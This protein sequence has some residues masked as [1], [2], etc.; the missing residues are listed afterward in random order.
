MTERLIGTPPTLRLTLTPNHTLTQ[1]ASVVGRLARLS[2]SAG[3]AG[4]RVRH[5]ER[6]SDL[7]VQ[8]LS[9]RNPLV[10]ELTGSA[11]TLA[12]VYF[13]LRDPRG[14]GRWVWDVATGF[15]EGHE[16]FRR[17]R[18]KATRPAAD[19]LELAAETALEVEQAAQELQPYLGSAGL[20]LDPA[21]R[22]SLPAGL[23]PPGH[24]SG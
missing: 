16:E 17:R 22:A 1:V 7:V 2:E 19:G 8:E 11:T 10:V 21:D 3:S 14:V 23:E 18:L 20:D 9:V 5:G 4:R 13:A 24:E 12:V 15:A 6:P